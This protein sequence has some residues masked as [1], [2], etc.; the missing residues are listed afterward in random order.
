MASETR[1][2]T[3]SVVDRLKPG[4]LVFDDRVAGFCV[5]CQRASKVY[6]V[7]CR[8]KGRQR[9][10]TIG[11]HGSPWTAERARAKATALLG[12][13]AAGRDP[14]TA[15][16]H[17]KAAGTFVEFAERY[18]AEYAETKK[19]PRSVASDRTNLELNILPRW[20]HRRLVDI[21][22]ADVA[23]L[24]H[25]LRDKPGA[26]NRCLSLLHKM[27][28]L[29]EVWG[30]RPEGSNPVR[31][32]DRYPERKMERFLSGAEMARI[33]AELQ[34]AET[35]RIVPP[36]GSKRR[37]ADAREG[38]ENPYLIAAV[39]L[40]LLTGARRS[41]ILTAKWEYVDFDRAVLRL[42]DS[43]TGAKVVP[44][45]A[46]ALAT[47]GKLPRIDGNDFILPGHV[48]GQHLANVDDFWR[49]IRKTAKLGNCRLH[50][51]RH[52]FA[53]VGAAS[54]DSLLLI[55]KVLGHRQA[56]TTAKYSHL[57]ADPVRAA[58]DRI[59]GS[60]AAA[61]AGQGAEIV[62]IERTNRRGA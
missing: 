28:G 30:L 18:V 25:A 13:I 35:E 3:K 5:R 1:R 26:A 54:G 43:K 27:F 52:S 7:K 38:G 60:I 59:S 55:G 22:R 11:R 31:H 40:L 10:I 50:D 34:R 12:E 48:H 46:P 56:Q 32:I 39:R 20:K 53:S 42:P 47:L 29:A 15:R 41:E 45:G 8:S 24:H 61:M 57:S 33:G 49:A 58:A 62:P 36:K 44:L 16:D 9:W 4:N 6:A 2:I 21:A 37:G 17:E 19:K 14:A 23:Q 51:L